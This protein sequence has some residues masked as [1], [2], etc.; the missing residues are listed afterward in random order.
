[1]PGGDRFGRVYE[2]LQR[3]RNPIVQGEAARSFQ[4]ELSI[5]Q[6]S[7]NRAVQYCHYKNCNRNEQTE[8]S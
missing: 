6:A 2:V 7:E 1:M 8:A 4:K 5:T 3:L